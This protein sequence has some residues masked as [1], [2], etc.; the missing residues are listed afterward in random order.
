VASGDNK[1]VCSDTVRSV[2]NS[3]D[4]PEIF[5]LQQR[6]VGAVVGAG[7]DCLSGFDENHCDFDG[8]VKLPLIVYNSSRKRR[9][10]QTECAS[11]TPTLSVN[12]HL[13]ISLSASSNP[14][15]LSGAQLDARGDA[16]TITNNQVDISLCSST[17]SSSNIVSNAHLD[18][19][20]NNNVV[21][22]IQTEISL[23]Q[24]SNLGLVE[25]KNVQ[26][27]ISENKSNSAID[28]TDFSTPNIAH[29]NQTTNAQL[30]SCGDDLVIANNQF[31]IS[32]S[33]HEYPDCDLSYSANNQLDICNGLV[34]GVSEN[35]V[36]GQTVPIESTDYW[37]D[38]ETELKQRCYYDNSNIGRSSAPNG[39]EDGRE[40]VLKVDGTQR[41]D[42]VTENVLVG[43][44]VPIESTDY[45]DDFETD[46]KQRCFYDN[47][48]IG[49]FSAPNSREDSRKNVLNVDTN[50]RVDC[51]DIGVRCGNDHELVAT[52]SRTRGLECENLRC[53][54]D[55][56]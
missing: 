24:D 32:L 19:C 1:Q 44:A 34:N 46:V 52:P 54:G 51:G 50:Q 8:E 36:V 9:L 49:R 45:W 22:N 38:S 20:E 42:C 16:S 30:D 11:N 55:V 37:D 28:Q 13:E 35:V 53:S 41:V 2:E 21:A 25:N 43:Q 47:S 39:T 3:V 7:I 31:D 33:A 15:T 10:K 23:L 6:P 5:V 14:T 17:N 56:G 4:E 18:I 48:N 27:A 29:L 12:N 26:F 40:N